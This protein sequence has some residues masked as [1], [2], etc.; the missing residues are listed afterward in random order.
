MMKGLKRTDCCL[1]WRGGRQRD[2]GRGKGWIISP[3]GSREKLD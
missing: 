1:A 2:G 3:N